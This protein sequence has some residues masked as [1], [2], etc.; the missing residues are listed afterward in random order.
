MLVFKKFKKNLEHVHSKFNLPQEFGTS[1]TIAKY[2]K[3][4]NNNSQNTL[5]SF[6]NRWSTSRFL[7]L[8][9]FR[10]PTNGNIIASGNPHLYVQKNCVIKIEKTIKCETI[11]KKIESDLSNLSIMKSIIELKRHVF[12]RQHQATHSWLDYQFCHTWI[13]Q[14]S[15]QR[16]WGL[17]RNIGTISEPDMKI[18]RA[19]KQYKQP[20]QFQLVSKERR[21]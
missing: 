12:C 17:K 18:M 4:K 13:F 15:G 7:S 20:T 1:S 19:G 3:T 10:F 16:N 8:A 11:Q 9:F 2:H 5:I 21:C 6:T 14:I